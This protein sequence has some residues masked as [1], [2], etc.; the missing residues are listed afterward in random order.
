MT[1]KQSLASS[2]LTIVTSDEAV[3][4]PLVD[5]LKQ[6]RNGCKFLGID[7]GFYK[8]LGGMSLLTIIVVCVSELT[9]YENLTDITVIS[10]LEGQRTMLNTDSK[11]P[12]CRCKFESN[13][14]RQ[15][16]EETY[17]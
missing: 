7:L 2:V 6:L 1:N 3:S 15:K 5:V 10:L 9:R 11:C 13:T 16:S 14:N 4:E 17:I 8:D 12:Y